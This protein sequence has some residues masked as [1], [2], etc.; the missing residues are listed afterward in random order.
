MLEKMAAWTRKEKSFLI[1]NVVL[2]LMA[3][4]LVLNLLGVKL[5]SVGQANYWLDHNEPVC[6]ARFE[7]HSSLLDKDRCCLELRKQL[8]CEPW[9]WSEPVVVKG[10]EFRADRRCFTGKSAVDY[11]VNMKEYQYCR[12]EGVLE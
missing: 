3:T 11:L 12:N 1:L 8:K 10:E 7:G 6:V 9:E 5:P 4:M 2:G